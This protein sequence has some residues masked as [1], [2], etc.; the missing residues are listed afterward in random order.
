MR[1]V[2]ITDSTRPAKKWKATFANT[3]KGEKVVHFG[4]FGYEDYTT[5]ATDEQRTRYRA[6][7]TNPRENHSKPDTPAA[8][9]YHILWGDSKSRLANIKSFKQKFNL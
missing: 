6:R 1:L 5:G 4:A 3:S 9:S 8:L 7:H 2:S